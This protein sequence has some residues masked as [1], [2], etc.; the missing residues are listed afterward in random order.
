MADRRRQ[1][2]EVI[3]KDSGG[4]A[5][6]VAKRLAQELV[7]RD[8]VDILGGFVLSPNTLAA[9]DVSSQAGR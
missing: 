7:V 2:I 9:A 6:D 5:P 8:N 1:A 3:R 4:V